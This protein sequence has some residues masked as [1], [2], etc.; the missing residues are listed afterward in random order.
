MDNTIRKHISLVCIFLLAITVVIFGKE[1]RQNKELDSQKFRTSKI[2]VRQVLPSSKDIGGSLPLQEVAQIEAKRFFSALEA[3]P[4]SFV[5]RS[6]IKFVTF[7]E[8]PT[9]KK[10]PVAGLAY[11]NTMILT[12]GFTDTTVYHELFHIFDPKRKERKWTRLNAKEFVYTGSRYYEEEVSKLKRKRRNQ[13]VASGKFDLDFASGYAMS[14]ELEDRAETFAYMISHKDYFLI[15]AK[16]SPVLWKKMMFIID[17][18]DN[19]KLLG[20]D[21]WTHNFNVK[22]LSELELNK[23]TQSSLTQG[24]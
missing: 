20:K 10:I 4:E 16:N 11:G 8:K 24:E 22:D 3:L 2:V 12:V 13:N 18:T 19:N 6:G 9:L 14:N 1:R 5:Q 21:F 15:K 7:I 17:F 23:N